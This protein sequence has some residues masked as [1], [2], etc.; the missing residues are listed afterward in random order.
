MSIMGP[1]ERFRGQTGWRGI[2][3]AASLAQALIALDA[4]SMRLM[5]LVYFVIRAAIDTTLMLARPARRG[6]HTLML[7]ARH[8]GKVRDRVIRSISIKVMHDFLR[9]QVTPE[10]LLH[11][12]PM[13]EHIATPRRIGMVGL[14]HLNIA[15]GVLRATALP[16]CVVRPTALVVAEETQRLSAL[17]SARIPR[18]EQDRLA[19]SA[20]TDGDKLFTRW[21]RIGVHR[22]S[23]QLGAMPGAV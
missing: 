13:F 6:V 15:L 5:W 3:L 12:Q 11:D 14:P 8:Y 23:L 7:G 9:G 16:A 22:N 2:D 21:G 20:L 17:Q 18:G 4:T 1:T 19:T 10:M